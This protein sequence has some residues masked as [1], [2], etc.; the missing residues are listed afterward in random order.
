LV[1]RPTSLRSGKV[2][3]RETIEFLRRR[4]ATPRVTISGEIDQVERRRRAALDP[5]E[6][7]EPRLARRGARASQRPSHQRVDQARFADVGSA[8]ER[9]LRKPITRKVTR[10]SGAGDELSD[11]LQSERLSLSPANPST[12][13]GIR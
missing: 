8:H 13:P 7:G 12:A 9:K 4:I 1:A 3:L 6:I 2:R 10:A 5:V 11:Y